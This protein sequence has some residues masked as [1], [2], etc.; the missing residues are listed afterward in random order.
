MAKRRGKRTVKRT[1]PVTESNGVGTEDPKEPQ[2]RTQGALFID[3]ELE[4]QRQIAAVRTVRDVEIEHL[5]TE[6]RLHRS[7]FNKELL[8]KPV[9]QF[10]EENFPDLS[11]VNDEEN[12]K[13]EV[14][15][16]DKYS[17]LSMN[18]A[19]QRD[20]H[21]SFLHKLSVAHPECSAVIPS[22]GGYEY[23]SK[24][25]RTSL[26]GALHFNEFEPSETQTLTMQDFPHTPVSHRKVDSLLKLNG[27][28]HS[29]GYFVCSAQ[30]PFTLRITFC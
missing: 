25:G 2:V 8:Q 22:L 11:V 13:F 12:K 18:C 24:A 21:A 29:D 4:V 26:L 9:L 20:V 23:S 16:N 3:I 17:R 30:I 1:E 15:W 19:D 28:N 5:L 10:F 6:L 7:Y 14:R 27:E